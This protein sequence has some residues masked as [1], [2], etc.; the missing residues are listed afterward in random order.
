[1]L[2]SQARDSQAANRKEGLMVVV[3]TCPSCEADAEHEVTATRMRGIYTEG[4]E[5]TCME[6][7]Y[8]WFLRVAF[9]PGSGA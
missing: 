3:A 9:Q 5:V 1:M 4:Y 2:A 6:C 8:E 7:L